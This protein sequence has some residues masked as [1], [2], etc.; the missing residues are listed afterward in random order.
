MK[1]RKESKR[2]ELKEKRKKLTREE[3]LRKSRKI[4]DKIIELPEFQSKQNIS[5]YVAKKKAGEVETEEMIKSWIK[6]DKKIL[7]PFVDGSELKLS[8][9]KNFEKDLEKG[10]FGIKEPRKDKKRLF[11]IKK[12]EV[13]FVP[14]LG[15]DLEGNRL[16]FGK[17]YY[18]RFLRKASNDTDFIVLAFDFQISKEIPHTETDV[19]VHKIITEK[20]IIKTRDK[21]CR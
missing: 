12:V 10:K 19:P 21:S 20:R 7:V 5:I 2:K 4:H 13:I 8:L 6:K 11:P 15:F 1:K 3:V 14:G 17:G 9:L 16:G 18:D